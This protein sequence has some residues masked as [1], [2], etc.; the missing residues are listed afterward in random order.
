MPMWGTRAE[1]V[2]SAFWYTRQI[3]DIRQQVEVN[4]GQIQTKIKVNIF[5]TECT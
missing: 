2:E 1:R 3:Y 4:A 5:N